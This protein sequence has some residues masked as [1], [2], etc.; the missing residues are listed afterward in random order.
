MP[1]RGGIRHDVFIAGFAIAAGFLSATESAYEY[2]KSFNTYSSLMML[3]F[4]TGY[5]RPVVPV[6]PAGGIRRHISITPQSGIRWLK[7]T[8]SAKSIGHC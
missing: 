8:S 3:W 6:I 2:I 7:P 1:T 4:R 5:D